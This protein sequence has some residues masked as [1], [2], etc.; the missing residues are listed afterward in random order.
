MKV[1]KDNSGI[2][3][4]TKFPLRTTCEHCE[5]E[6]EIEKDDVY[7]GYRGAHMVKCPVC[8]EVTW[9]DEIDDVRITKKNV[10]FPDHFYRMGT[11]KE[12]KELSSDDIKSY[13]SKAIDYFRENPDS[14]CYDATS[15]DTDVTVYNYSGDK[16]YR[17]IVAK[18]YYETGIEYEPE[19]YEAQE[20]NNWNWNNKG[21]RYRNGEKE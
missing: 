20:R 21:V 4:I 12:A 8:G 19:D 3:N 5:S 16:E 13:I 2:N 17:I 9:V 10:K 6:L 7:V 18:N 14:F 1:I 11:S 15:G